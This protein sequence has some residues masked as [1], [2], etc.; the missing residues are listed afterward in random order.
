MKITNLK[1][2]HEFQERYFDH[3]LPIYGYALRSKQKEMAGEILA[4]IGR[5]KI[6]I[7]EAGV[8]IGKTLAYLLPAALARRARI[9]EGHVPTA[10]PNGR[11]A[12]VLIATST[13]ALQQ[14]I[15]RDYVPDQSRILEAHG[16]IR[17][18]LALV[19]RKG[20]GHYLCEDKLKKFASFADPHTEA[21]LKAILA[22]GIVDIDSA[23]G[24]TPY[25]KR[26]ICVDDRCGQDCPRFGRCRYT[27]FLREAQQG[28]SDFQVCNHNFFLAD[29]RRRSAGQRPLMPDYQAVIIDEAHKFLDAARQMYGAELSLASLEKVAKDVNG[30][31]FGQR[32]P[33]GDICRE[34]ERLLSRARLLFQFLSKEAPE[35]A[36][37]EDIERHPAKI[38]QRAEKLT[39]SLKTAA[40][41]LANLLTARKTT[42]KFEARQRAALRTLER[43]SESLAAF[44]RHR[45]LVYWLEEAEP[46]V[47]AVNT[48]A[49]NRP[50]LTVLKGIPKDLGRMLCRDIW[51]KDIPFVLTSG[52]LSASGDFSH[53]K[54]AL[55]IDLA[56]ADRISETSK[57]SPFDYKNNALL[58]ISETTP[59][60]DAAEES[61]IAA[62]ARESERL[63][64]ASHG[65]A[66]LLFTSYK[67]ME[68]TH[69]RIA[70]TGLPYPIFRLDRGG[71][72]V[73]D[74]FR[75]GKNGVL[76][77]SG[78]L[79]EGIDIPGDIL[80]LLIIVRLPFAAPDPV[81]EWERSLYPDTR[82]YIYNVVTPEM[83]VRLKQGF[84]RLIRK[85]TD[86]GVVA[87][88]DSRANTRGAYR[89]RI[90]TALPPCLVT[91]KI[92]D[93]E[94]FFRE[95]K[96]PAYFA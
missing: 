1:D 4:A 63:I 41:D 24:L 39:R 3:I 49:K 21:L 12:P 36:A 45:E 58:Y 75:R 26:K 95:K 70:A 64:R 29:I 89:S 57:P 48:S 40:D 23:A 9:N 66:A 15:V 42:I 50:D 91:S 54:R 44:I 86:T 16:N 5:R 6:I 80:S 52:T 59:Y 92:A 77:A 27:R 56:K 35:D 84:G 7:A 83:L 68:L 51:S 60:P 67:A 74:Q 79:W 38:N 25:M 20:K 47:A 62:I 88:L 22:S 14:A 69:E 71:G 87:I 30:F 81:S 73:I 82:S 10:L 65:H 37:G 34:A 55:G 85:E 32:V 94:R 33:T 11:Q 90:L 72:R 53:L 28:G 43:S 13:I 31:T 78:S 17:A 61:Y 18:P 96:Q 8:G 93:V 76:F 46:A 19:L 2:L